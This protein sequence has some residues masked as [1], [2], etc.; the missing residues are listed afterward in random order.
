[1]ALRQEQHGADIGGLIRGGNDDVDDDAMPL[2]KVAKDGK[3][4]SA[5]A[6]AEAAASLSKILSLL[7]ELEE[8]QRRRNAAATFNC[9]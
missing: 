5:A 7:S 9:V 2:Q 8:V 1:M 3:P 4:P 6:E